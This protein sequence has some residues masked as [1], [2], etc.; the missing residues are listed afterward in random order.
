MNYMPV[1][2]KVLKLASIY[3]RAVKQIMDITLTP[4]EARIFELLR[5]VVQAKAPDTTLR[6]AGGWVRDKLLGKD[7]NDIDVSPDNMSGE[8]FALL[9]KEFMDEHGLAAG[10]VAC[11]MTDS[12]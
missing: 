9:T 11:F 12:V 5:A 10:N 4:Q 6:V 3:V 7:S 8:E 1:K 2:D